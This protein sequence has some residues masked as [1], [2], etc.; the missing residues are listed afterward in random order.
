MNEIEKNPITGTLELI[1]SSIMSTK[2]KY[3]VIGAGPCGLAMVRCLKKKNIPFQAFEYSDDVGGIWNQDNPLSTMYNSAHLISSKTMTQ[4][5]EFPFGDDVADFPS[6][7]VL[8]Q[9]FKDFAKNFN[10]YENIRFN[11][12]IE[13]VT[14]NDDGSMKVAYKDRKTGEQ[15]EEDYKGVIFAT[16]LFNKGNENTPK[17]EGVETFPGEVMHAANYRSNDVF[18]GKRVLIVGC[19]NSAADISVDAVHRAESVHMSV[20]RGYYFVPKY[21]L[22]KPMDTVNGAV[23]KILPEKIK[24]AIDKRVLKAFAG[25]P[26]KFG[27][28]K[29]HYDIYESHPVIN[30]LILHHIGH[31]DIDVVGD[32]EK[33]EGSTVHFK[34]GEKH[35]YDLILTATGYHI[36]FKYIDKDLINWKNNCPDLHLNI[37]HPKFDNIMV[38]GLIEATGIGWQGRY[39][40]AEL[41]SEYLKLK[42]TDP[43]NNKLQKFE[44]EIKANETDLTNGMKYLKLDRMAYYVHKET[45]MDTVK[46]KIA[47]LA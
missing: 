8:K 9:Y 7:K 10:L 18:A 26:V 47:G 19:G 24:K 21:I 31:G 20:R 43:K 33:I 12:I 39:D 11:S 17:W 29:P 38:L 16:G 3:A 6:Q 4:Y 2:S 46:E 36:K 30:S 41:V 34:N 40:Q 44:S 1:R 15:I 25:D 32:I 23:K 14:R 37:F 35:D 22:G 28:P 42:E 45:Y 27:F 5:D 13:K